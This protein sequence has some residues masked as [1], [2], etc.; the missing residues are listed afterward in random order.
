MINE[1]IRDREIRLIG[2]DGEQLG[3]MSARDAM[4]LAREANLDLVKIA[5]TAKPPVCKIIDYGKYRYEQARREK[6]ARKKQKT[7]EVKEIRLSPNI[8][9]NDLNTKVNQAR[10]FVSGGN[11]VKVAV[12]FRG[13]ELAHTAVGK[14]ILEDFAQKLSDIAVIDKPAKL[15]GKSMVMFLVEKRN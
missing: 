6:E 8:D 7:I 5:P 13:R 10:K 1:Q 4:K 9:T 3:I 11:K 15:E 14:T 12:R 2:E